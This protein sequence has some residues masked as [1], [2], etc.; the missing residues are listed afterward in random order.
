MGKESL[1]IPE[2]D[3]VEK[4]FSVEDLEITSPSSP[5]TQ[6]SEP[7]PVLVSEALK[8][9]LESALFRSSKRGSQFLRFVVEYRLHNHLE[10]LKERTIGAALFNRPLDYSTGDDSVVRAQA[11]EVRRRL[12]KYYAT[13]PSDN[14]VR[15]D[16]P[17][18]SYSPEFKWRVLRRA[19]DVFRNSTSL[20]VTAETVELP[21]SRPVMILS[22]MRSNLRKLL[23]GAATAAICGLVLLVVLRHIRTTAPDPVISQ[24][25][26][27]AFASS[28]P[29]LIC[30]PKPILYRPSAEIYKRT[31]QSP[32][33]FD[34]ELDRMTHPPHLRPDDPIRWG[35]MIEFYDYG[36]SK[37]DVEAAVRLSN[38]LGRQGK[39][40][41][42]R[43]GDGYS[44]EDLRN[45]PAVMVG[46][47]SNPVTIEMTAGLHFSFVDDEKGI[48]I[49]EQ[50]PSG[51]SWYSKH[52]AVGEDYGLVT[53]LIDSG[54]GQFVVLVA[55]IEAS[56]SDAAADLIVHP[57]GLE[58]ALR[59][60]P[61]DWPRKNV[62]IVVSTTV[63]DGVA[64]PPRVVAIHA[65]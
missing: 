16:L 37:G 51:R 56:G 18:G 21:V 7:S 31:A 24:F 10:P 48:R 23:L 14:P 6:D 12:E 47:F 13:C 55:G 11:R 34:H 54:T 62:Q 59:D 17:V 57:D 42:L 15:I 49:Q 60:S 25:W 8:L 36:V 39:D 58:K 1:Q 9:I 5:Q 46:A 33:E 26:S 4:P 27:P 41:E 38:F 63:K 20:L 32:G 45:S 30:L 29:L 35:D 28:K 43:F 3:L 52:G 53:R 44:S 50:G 61:R 22:G 2:H 64:G 19:E 65:W 40:S